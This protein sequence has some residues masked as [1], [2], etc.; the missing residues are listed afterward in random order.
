MTELD[1]AYE[2]A[3]D[4]FPDVPEWHELGVE[5]ARELEA[6]L[7]SRGSGG[8]AETTELTVARLDGDGSIPIRVYRPS[9]LEE[10][11]P[12]LVFAHGGGFV[13]GTL[14]SADD[15]A[16]RLA[17]NTGSVV[18]SVDYRLA[19]EHP[20]PAGLDDVTVVVE[21][22][23][24]SADELGVDPGRVGVAGSSAGANLAALAARRAEVSVSLAVLFYP[25]VDPTLGSASHE[26]HADAPLLTR[27]DLDW[28]WRLYRDD[29]AIPVD[30]P[31]LS[32]LST[33]GGEARPFADSP[34]TVV[35]TAGVDPLRDDGA[36]YADALDDAGVSV[37][38]LHYPDAPHGF[39]SLAD[40]VPGAADAWDDLATAV[41]ASR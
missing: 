17:A 11:A 19:P 27:A 37:E 21:W 41:L 22:T 2:R 28:F 3:I 30:D 32:P 33:V 10:P 39:L 6:E 38:H 15:L 35:V 9:G 12:A 23:V 26:E 40:T 25:M 31:R 7:F 18:V 34:P 16:R 14:D 20:C 36:R 4:D 29:G 13:L 8:P 5:G 1:P 24:G